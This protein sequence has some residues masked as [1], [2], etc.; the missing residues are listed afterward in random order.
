[1]LILNNLACN[2]GKITLIN[3]NAN[4]A[5]DENAQHRCPNPIELHL[6]PVDY[7]IGNVRGQKRVAENL[8]FDKYKYLCKN[9]VFKK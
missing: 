2:V 4:V 7:H 5:T 6:I 3:G 9:S 8:G 1:M